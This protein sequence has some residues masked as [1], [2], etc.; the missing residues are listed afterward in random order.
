MALNV[1]VVDDSAVMRRMIVRALELSGLPLARVL[2]AGTGK[3]GLASAL[4]EDVDLALLDINM[5]EMNGLTMLAELRKHPRTAELPVIM[6][7]T[8]GSEQRI[9]AIRAS[10]ASFVR[11]PF[12]PESLIAAVVGAVGGRDDDD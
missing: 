6:V 10:G 8:E 3:A 5:P 4:E 7:S 1:L 9:E 11:K 12:T 2:E